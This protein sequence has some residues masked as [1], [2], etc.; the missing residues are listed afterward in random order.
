MES[1][2]TDVL[3][4]GSG[5]AGLRAAIEAARNGVKTLVVS[6]SSIETG[7]NSALAGGGLS[8]GISENEIEEHAERTL[9]I[10][11]D[12]NDRQLVKELSQ[13]GKEAIRFLAA[14][15]IDLDHKPPLRHSVYKPGQSEKIFG[16]RILTG[17][18]VRECLRHGQIRF[19]PHF[20]VY[21]LIAPEDQVLGALGFD[22]DGK[23]CA[24][25]SKAVILA[26]G[27]GGAIYAR[28]DN[29]KRM[30]G[31]GY[32]MAL[33]AGLPLI[34]MEFVQFYP[35]GFAEPGLPSTLIY[36]P[37]PNSVRMVDAQGNDFL[38][39]H[40]L[41]G[42]LDK[43]VITRRDELSYLIYKASQVGGVHMDYTRVPE[44]GWE[45]YPLNMFPQQRFPFKER[46]FR[47]APIAHFFMGGIQIRPSGETK[48]MG[49]YAA[50]EITGGLHG[51]NRMGGNALAECLV[52]GANAGLS[53]SI[54]AKRHTLKKGIFDLRK[55][56]KPLVQGKP[57]SRIQ[58]DLRSLRKRIQEMAWTFAGPIRDEAGLK[59][60]LS[61]MEGVHSDLKALRVSSSRELIQMK[62]VENSLLVI[63][64][65][66]ISSLAR[67][68]SRGAFQREDFPHEGG[69]EFLKR[70]SV[71]LKGKDEGLTVSWQGLS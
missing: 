17:R 64:A 45:T 10:G 31:D 1:L 38:I 36:P 69:K 55:W 65:I 13:S 35:F 4:V 49:L 46:P 32:A 6:K 59:K 22:K 18:L 15:G 25:H 7:S 39:K 29:H 34:D 58:L 41:E 44:A 37:Y 48:V 27:G 52:F 12:L 50:G 23:P 67:K 71:R 60:A 3:I 9:Q 26:T 28:N 57:N 70:V 19:L 47:I 63:Q 51:A 43:L 21:S 68:E 30:T 2:E 66:V 42:D 24:I 56:L 14:L 62:E 53:A 61:L 16:G 20:Y 33:E 8:I 5:L 40:G 54:F 11:R